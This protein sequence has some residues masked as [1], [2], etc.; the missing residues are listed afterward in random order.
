MSEFEV[1]DSGD[2]LVFESGMHRD[3]NVDKV[4]FDLALDGPMFQRYAEHL[5]K[6]AKKYEARN[7]MKARS[8]E[9][10]DRFKESALRHFLQ[11]Y[12]C[13]RDEDHAAAVMFNINGFEY[14]RDRL[15]ASPFAGALREALHTPAAVLPPGID[16]RPGKFYP[17]CGDPTAHKKE[18][19]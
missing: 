14:V 11:W 17:V 19:K 13:E 8:V 16:L 2:R 1:K 18:G 9:E 5:T 6:G 15:A 12:R 3:T 10:A 4:R 7:W